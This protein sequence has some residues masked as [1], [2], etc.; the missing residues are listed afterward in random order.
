MLYGGFTTV[1]IGAYAMPA[2]PEVW[3]DDKA[4]DVSPAVACTMNLAMQY[5]GVYLA[6]QVVQTWVVFNGTSLET[7]KLATILQMATNTVNFAPML[8][9][10]FIGARIRALQIDPKHGAPQAWAQN[11]FYL[12]AYSVLAQLSLVIVVPYVLGGEVKRGQSEGD[13]TFELPNPSLYFVLSGVR[14]VLMLALYGGFTAVIVS[15]FTIEAED[16]EDT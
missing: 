15:V 6:I 3:G 16:P 4:P 12:C 8:A 5:F 11:C 10:L 2:P 14:Y 9:I 7:R 1:C 13:V